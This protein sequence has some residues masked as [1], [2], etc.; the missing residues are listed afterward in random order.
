MHAIAGTIGKFV[1]VGVVACS[2]QELQAGETVTIG[3]VQVPA[4]CALAR[5]EHPRLLFTKQDLPRL[6]E[7]LKH[8]RIAN[9]RLFLNG[10]EPGHSELHDPL[11]ADRPDRRR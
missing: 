8:P 9:L 2:A 6:R 4:D 5:K 3:G 7:R 1:L 10:K 11:L